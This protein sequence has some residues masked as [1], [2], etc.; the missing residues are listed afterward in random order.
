[1][2][3][4]VEASICCL[5]HT[6]Q[7]TVN[8]RLELFKGVCNFFTVIGLYALFAF[9]YLMHILFVVRGKTENSEIT[10]CDAE[11]KAST[12]EKSSFEKRQEKVRILSYCVRSHYF[13]IM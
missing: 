5:H 6:K 13:D 3:P 8:V 4:A 11:S 9:A 12:Q 1:M 7:I 2:T 10:S